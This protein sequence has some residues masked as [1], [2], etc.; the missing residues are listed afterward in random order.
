MSSDFKTVLV[1]D[2]TIADITSDLVYA[3]KSGAN[4]TT[5][6]PFAATS[7]TS[8]VQVYNIQVPSENIVVARDALISTPL[9]FRINLSQVPVGQT[10]ISWGRSAALQAFPLASIMTTASATINNSTTSCNLQDVLPQILRLNNNRELFRHN[11]MCPSLPDQEFGVYSDADGANSSPLAGFANKSYDGDLT[12]RGAHPCLVYIDHYTVAGGYVDHSPVSTLLTDTWIVSVFSVT[13]EPI[14]LSPFIYA[15]PENNKQGMLGVNNM[16]FT[17]NINSSLN[18]LM[19]Y[20]GA[21]AITLTAGV[22]ADPVGGRWAANSNL[23]QMSATDGPAFLNAPPAGASILLRLLSSQPSDKLQTRNVVPYFDLPRYL[24]SVNAALP[25]NANT[26]QAV[27]SQAIQLAQLP[28]YFI[29]VA[30]KSM[31]T[32][33]PQDTSS[34]LTIRNISINLNNQSGLLSSASA[35]DLWRLST[36]NHSQQSWYEFCGKATVATADGQSA[37]VPTTGSMLVISPTDLSL[38]D[39][40]SCG[41]LG[42]FSLQFTAQV[43]NQFGVNVPN[44]ELCVIA[45][46]SGIMVLSQGTTNIY[47]GMLTREAV[48][49]AKEQKPVEL[50]DRMVGGMLSRGLAYHP[51][52]FGMS[53]SAM[54]AG[55]QSAG[56]M[57]SRMDRMC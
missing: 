5:Y 29:I 14:F 26:T 50:P 42:A 41:S 1:K 53:G 55:A 31:A 4:S 40:L 13:T 9:Q 39:N 48:G 21:G 32:Q 2:A 54:S 24:T 20:A 57:K 25:I 38:P 23:F 10:A 52:R 17:F 7:S 36:K 8:S 56:A 27:S 16:A 35:N 44:V 22:G 45:C 30:R 11:G 46:N 12:P 47:T 15:D 19:S 3:V 34:F 18:R 37:L 49:F 28:D 6:Q 51:R 43:F 33:T